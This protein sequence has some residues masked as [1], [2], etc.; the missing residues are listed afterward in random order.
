MTPFLIILSLYLINFNLSTELI[1]N[2][3]V[4][5]YIIVAL[6]L[7]LSQI[8]AGLRWH[9]LSNLFN[10]KVKLLNAINFG[11]RFSAIGSLTFSGGAD[12]YKFIYQKDSKITAHELTSVIISEKAISFFTMILMAVIGLSINIHD[13]KIITIILIIFFLIIIISALLV[14]NINKFPYINLI[15]Y[16]FNKIKYKFFSDKIFLIKMV[17]I[18][19]LTQ[20]FS[21]ILYA[22]FF[23][24]IAS[25]PLEKLIFI[26]PI[27][28]LIVSFSFFTFN[29]IGVREIFFILVADIL[30]ISKEDSFIVAANASL[31][32]TLYM[33]ISFL[34]S[35]RLKN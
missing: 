8:L 6:I 19:I 28:N 9:V 13:Y 5:F 4:S 15:N 27:T 7:F 12:L 35:S 25:V 11:F 34:I 20:L 33:I 26:I 3:S 31:V 22:F 17:T 21:I 16:S 32:I 29:G 18:S 24:N 23:S 1:I 2:F 30:F 10:S 14:N